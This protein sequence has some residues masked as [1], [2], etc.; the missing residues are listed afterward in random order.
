MHSSTN[1]MQRTELS[2]T[3]TIKAKMRNSFSLFVR[4]H[5]LP[6]P[7]RSFHG[8]GRVYARARRPRRPHRDERTDRTDGWVP[9]LCNCTN[10]YDAKMKV[11]VECMFV[12]GALLVAVVVLFVFHF[13][14][15]S[16]QSRLLSMLY[17][18][19]TNRT[20]EFGLMALITKTNVI[21]LF[22]DHILPNNYCWLELNR[23]ICVVRSMAVEADIVNDHCK[24]QHLSS[25]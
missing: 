14:H 3:I 9:S 12:L 23:M 24:K 15:H 18:Q 11:R 8:R 20:K 2:V 16:V 4:A 19:C 7:K 17:F 25:K 5:T 6:D 13:V 22:E 1:S 21:C 10:V